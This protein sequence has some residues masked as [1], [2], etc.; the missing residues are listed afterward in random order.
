M[1]TKDVKELAKLTISQ[2][3]ERLVNFIKSLGLIDNL[4]IPIIKVDE[5]KNI[6]CLPKKENYE[7][8]YKC[9]GHKVNKTKSNIRYNEEKRNELI[10]QKRKLQ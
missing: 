9:E 2:C 3:K 10:Q 7:I 1:S 4:S 5:N 6:R 8:I